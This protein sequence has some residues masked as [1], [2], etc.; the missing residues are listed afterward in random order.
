MR[1]IVY[2]VVTFRMSILFKDVYDD[3][4]VSGIPMLPKPAN[5]NGNFFQEL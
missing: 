4:I 5:L 2:S 1:N 3:L